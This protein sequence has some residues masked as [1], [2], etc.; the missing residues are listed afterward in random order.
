MAVLKYSSLLPSS[1][2]LKVSDKG[3]ANGVAGLGADGKVPS[4][5]LPSG[6]GGTG[7]QGIQGLQGFVG[8]S[9]L[10]GAIGLQG[11]AGSSG[12]SSSNKFIFKVNFANGEPST[13]IDL[14][15]G[16]SALVSGNNVTITHNVGDFPKIIT[17]L[18]YNSDI[19]PAIL[20]YRF[21]TVNNEMIIEESTKT[22]KFT[23]MI[24]SSVAASSSSGYALVNV[25]F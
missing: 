25:S 14:P 10:Q 22:S 7:T 3:V 17:Y 4:T 20:R 9:G 24:S 16:W 13:V 1:N 6:I 15:T 21:P 12:T 23:F 18:G 8:S 5:Q 19:A 2:F 11:P